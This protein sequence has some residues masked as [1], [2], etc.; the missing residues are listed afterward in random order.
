M[1]SFLKMAFAAALAAAAL[2]T[3]TGCTSTGKSEQDVTDDALALAEKARAFAPRSGDAGSEKSQVDPS[4]GMAYT[5]MGDAF[6]IAAPAKA[7]KDSQ[8][9][10]TGTVQTGMMFGGASGEQI[11]F[12]MKLIQTDRSLTSIG[13]QMDS[14]LALWD[15][16]GGQTEAN[17]AMLVALRE[18]YEARYNTLAEYG[19]AA[20][21]NVPDFSQLTT[22]GVFNWQSGYVVGSTPEAMSDA[23]AEAARA[24]G[25][26]QWQGITAI[27]TKT[28]AGESPVDGGDG[29]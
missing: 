20:M 2:T 4:T 8:N 28:G 29:E 21:P 9:T 10:A 13:A 23:E 17:A 1:N 15:A 14:L 24:A 5:S 12:A 18:Q 3:T 7:F 6:G 26:A 11:Q 22:M 19:K 27:A 16:E 25:V